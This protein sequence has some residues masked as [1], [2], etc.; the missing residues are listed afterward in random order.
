MLKV[1]TVKMQQVLQ[2]AEC[3]QQLWIKS[4]AS[5]AQ[6]PDSANLSDQT[7]VRMGCGASANSKLVSASRRGVVKEMKESLEAG[8]DPNAKDEWDNTGLICAAMKGETEAC[9]LLIEHKADVDFLNKKNLTAVYFA[10]E[11]GHVDTLKVLL[12]AKAHADIY[13]ELRQT[14]LFY[15]AWNQL[16]VCKILVE[17]G[18]KVDN[19]STKTQNTPLHEAARAGKTDICKFL[20]EKGADPTRKDG[21]GRNP[22]ERC[23]DDWKECKAYLQSVTPATA[24]ADAKAAAA[25]PADTQPAETPAETQTPAEAPAAEAA[26]AEAP[27]AEA[28]AEVPTEA[29]AEAT[30]AAEAPAAEPAEPAAEAAPAAEAVTVALPM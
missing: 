15:A 11:K 10:A 23:G 25:A 18:A 26:A 27:A 17:Y 5:C 2:L 7:P 3:T 20:I 8:A 28:A 22:Y 12:E 13:D 29:A 21:S 19:Q 30:E 1:C 4:G 24:P 16:E 6:R 14:P 9:S